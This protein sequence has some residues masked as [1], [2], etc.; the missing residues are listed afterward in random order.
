MVLLLSLTG[1]E[2]GAMACLCYGW[3]AEDDGAKGIVPLKYV[4][5]GVDGDLVI[6]YPEPYFIYLRGTVYGV[7]GGEVQFGRRGLCKKKLPRNT[8]L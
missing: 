3:L 7:E 4:E 8:L 5:Y 1:S 2:F 6:I